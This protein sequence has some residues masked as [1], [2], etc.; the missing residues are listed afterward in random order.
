M[1]QIYTITC[2]KSGRL[3]VGSTNHFQRRQS[4][5]LSALRSGSHHSAFLQR[6]FDKYGEDNLIWDIL[7]NCANELLLEREQYWYNRLEPVFNMVSPVRGPSDVLKK[8]VLQVDVITGHI[9]R[10]YPSLSDAATALG[11]S[12]SLISY[13]LHGHQRTAGG[14]YWILSS[15][16]DGRPIVIPA[17]KN[18]Q[19]GVAVRKT[20]ESGNVVATYASQTEAAMQV[21]VSQAAIGQALRTGC[22]AAGYRWETANE[23]YQ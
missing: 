19:W 11:I 5:H 21:G 1:G 17:V 2:Q 3:Y 7:E 20:A 9:I 12:H 16:Y 6:V 23:G 10:E 22:R 14:Y 8:A 13:V 4:E 15:E 18:T